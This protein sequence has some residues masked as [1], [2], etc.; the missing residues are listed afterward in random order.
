MHRQEPPP[1]ATWM[2]EHLTPEDRDEALAGDLLEQFRAG[3][4]ADWYRSQVAAAIAS[5]WCRGLLRRRAAMLFAVIWSFLSPV[6]MLEYLRHFTNGR[7]DDFTWALPFPWSTICALALGAARDMLFIWL[8]II[9]YLA[10]C[11][12]AIGNLHLRRTGAAIL[13]SFVVYAVAAT[14][15]IAIALAVGPHSNGPAIDWRS[16]TPIEALKNITL[17]SAFGNLPFFLGAATALWFLSLS[18]GRAANVA[19]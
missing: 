4:S 7:L 17:R 2:L 19:A 13:W 6:W 9:V 12:I 3:R 11:R 18:P 16:L 1:L 15:V 5:E 10:L 14:C 8:G